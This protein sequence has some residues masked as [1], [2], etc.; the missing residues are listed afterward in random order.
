MTTSPNILAVR[1]DESLYFA[2]VKYLE[3]FISQHVADRPEVQCIVLVYSA[4]NLSS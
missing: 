2:N 1:V 3:N 4:V